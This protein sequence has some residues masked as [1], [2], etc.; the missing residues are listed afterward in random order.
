MTVP[1]ATPRTIIMVPTDRVKKLV[2]GSP[3][4]IMP[5]EMD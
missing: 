3:R 1:S 4:S 2:F 5:R